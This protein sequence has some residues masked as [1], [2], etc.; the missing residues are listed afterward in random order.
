MHDFPDEYLQM[1]VAATEIQDHWKA[2]QYL[3]D[4][5][6]VKS[7]NAYDP[8]GQATIIQVRPGEARDGWTNPEWIPTRE[9]L[10]DLLLKKDVEWEAMGRPGKTFFY[11][12]ATY[13]NYQEL[14]SIV[15]G[16]RYGKQWDGRQWVPRDP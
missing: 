14:I 9:Q 15:M 4:W 12:P 3:L 11:D 6:F 1:A 13:Y 8:K 7:R 2:N 16:Q 10:K 5:D